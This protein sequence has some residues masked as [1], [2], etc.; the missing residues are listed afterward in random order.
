MADVR[1]GGDGPHDDGA[2]GNVD[3][4]SMAYIVDAVP[5]AA[6]PVPWS[7]ESEESEKEEHATIGGAET[8]GDR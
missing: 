3:A 8:A 2:G 5:P 1:A 6:L 7:E 4:V